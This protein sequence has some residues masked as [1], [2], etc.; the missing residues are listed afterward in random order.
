MNTSAG[1]ARMVIKRD[2]N[3]V[4]FDRERI[5]TAI[6]KA[7][8]S[9]GGTN[10]SI[11]ESLAEEVERRM[12]AMYTKGAIP[13]VEDIQDTVEETLIENDH[14]QTS[15]AYIIYRHERAQARAARI[16]KFEATDNIPY[17]KIYEVL[18]WN[19]AHECETV[20]GLNT[21]IA[22]GKFPDLIH[23]SNERYHN[24]VVRGAEKIIERLPE[25][26]IA[27]IAGPSSSG[28]TTTT[29]K[30]GEALKKAGR[31]L[32]AINID[33]YFFDL[34]MHPKDEFGDYD[35]E[36]PQ[37]LDLEL[38]NQHLV[39]LLEGK[40]IKTPHYDFKTGT[41][42]LDVHEMSL[43]PNQ[44]LLIDS[45]HGLYGDMTRDI[46]AAKKF[47]LYI[48][49]LG[50]LRDEHD[51]FMRWADNRLL[52]RMIRDSWHRNLQPIQT[53][54]H[55]HY[56]RRSELKNIIPF[57]GTADYLVNSALPYELPIHKH[58]LFRFFPQAMEQFRNE[59]KRQDAFIR[60]KRVFELLNPI[61]AVEDD[62]V[63]PRDALLREFIGGSV[64]TY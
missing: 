48:E 39:A 10:R 50:Q 61:T 49:T 42:K 38:I 51:T 34:E 32:V 5:A 2:G 27:I 9:V 40:T 63:V 4:P 46:P 35:Y 60:A 58:K 3:I 30:V 16:D 19:M 15:R 55:W 8:A 12:G 29:I 6:F 24:E 52:R 25:V 31:E 26:R 14:V 56:V 62:S 44:I 33:H 11:A 43:A 37:A 1:S 54:T 28:K 47:R 23:A 57:I 36:T 45:L 21:I 13:S 41:R 22:E 53:L 7:A 64:Y 59:P 18:R 17:K 20:E